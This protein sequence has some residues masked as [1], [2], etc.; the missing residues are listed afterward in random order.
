VASGIF[1][2]IWDNPWPGVQVRALRNKL[3][4]RWVGREDDLR[5]HLAEAQI[6]LEQA[7]DTDDPEERALLAGGGVGRIHS[8]KPAGQVVRD[9]VAEAARIL[10][11]WG[12]LV[13]SSMLDTP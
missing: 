5:A 13:N 1:D 3:T 12:T 8:L 4:M 10:D 7:N 11:E 9:I 6:T 2:I